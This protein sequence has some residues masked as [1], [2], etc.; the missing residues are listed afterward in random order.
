[1]LFNWLWLG[2]TRTAVTAIMRV[3]KIKPDARVLIV[4]PTEVLQKQ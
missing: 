3:L 1:M 2:K 4:V